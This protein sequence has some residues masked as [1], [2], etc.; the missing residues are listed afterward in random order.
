MHEG[1][2]ILYVYHDEDDHGW[3]FHG[4]EP[5]LMKHALLVA[6]KGIV[7]R[8]PSVCEVA[9]LPPGWF[10]HRHSVT[11]PWVREKNITEDIS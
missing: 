2:P 3:Q 11:A 7:S 6:L 5:S 9:D 8:D 1:S 10:A 4:A